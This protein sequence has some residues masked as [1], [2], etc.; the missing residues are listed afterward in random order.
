VAC[1]SDKLLLHAYL[2]GELDLVRSLQMEEH[3]KSCADC[4]LDVRQHRTL[5]AALQTP[6]LYQRAP[7][8]LR[9]KVLAAGRESGGASG[10]EAL[11]RAAV[12]RSAR[13]RPVL[14][15]LAVAASIAVVVFV[16]LRL[17]PGLRNGRPS[18]LFA[19]EIVASHIRSLQAGH[20]YD[21]E[22]TDQHTVKPWFDGKL[23]FSPP[24]RDMAAQG[25]PLLGGRLDYIG[26]RAVA[27]LVYQRRKHII[28]VFVWPESSGDA[29]NAEGF[30]RQEIRN[31]YN[32][33]EWRNGEMHFAAVSD[34]NADDLKQFI[35]LLRSP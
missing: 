5:R 8:S 28:N 20:L 14:E 23:D 12:L 27:A 35:Q 30:E 2:D 26:S 4:S 3:L 9:E 15:W 31:G 32:L 11:H 13:R 34:V 18:D 6:G 29:A 19:E 24:V 17:V 10:S 21:V 1:E 16:G 25:F 33:I 7:Q 22:S